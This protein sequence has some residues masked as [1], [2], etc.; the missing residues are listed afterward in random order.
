[1]KKIQL[2]TASL[3]LIIIATS[4][5]KTLRGHGDS[6]TENRT[7]PAFTQVRIEGE[8]TVIIDTSAQQKL[9]ITGYN[10]LLAF[11]TSTVKNN[12]LTL[13]FDADH[14]N[15]K[16]NNIVVR[17]K[18]PAFSSGY[19]NGSGNIVIN[20][21]TNGNNVAAEING[22]G[23]INFDDCSYTNTKLRING[24]GSINARYL[25]SVNNNVSIN[26]SGNIQAHCTQKLNA[27]ISGSGNIR[28]WGNPVD[29][30][31]SISGSGQVTKQ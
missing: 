11:Y 31:V 2:I 28:Y 23:N 12:V 13:K 16:N 6:S 18:I 22:S 27:S 1:M 8:G 20:N 21:F 4:C 7:V 25:L 17:I 5:N 19:I 9:E 10:N 30:N 3:L 14:Y 15:I 29:V 24:S 26:G